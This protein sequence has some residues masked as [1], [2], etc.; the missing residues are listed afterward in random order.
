MAVWNS[1]TK[2]IITIKVY[3]QRN[4]GML[5]IKKNVFELVFIRIILNRTENESVKV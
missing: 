3:F 2:Q 5:L 1:S 4:I